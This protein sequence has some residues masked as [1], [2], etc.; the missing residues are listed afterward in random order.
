[1]C[2]LEEEAE[3]KMEPQN[4][5]P[6]IHGKP[7]QDHQEEEEDG[8][9][10]TAEMEVDTKNENPYHTFP[11]IGGQTNSDGFTKIPYFSGKDHGA[12]SW[13]KQR[14]RG[15]RHE[16]QQTNEWTK[17]G[18]RMQDLSLPSSSIYLDPARAPTDEKGWAEMAEQLFDD[19]YP[20]T[21]DSS[22][23]T[24]RDWVARRAELEKAYF[25]GHDL[26]VGF[27]S[28]PEVA[29]NEDRFMVR[30]VS[31]TLAVATLVRSTETTEEQYAKISE[32]VQ[33]HELQTQKAQ[34]EGSIGEAEQSSDL[35]KLLATLGTIL[36]QATNNKDTKQKDTIKGWIEMA[37]DKQ[38]ALKAKETN[39]DN[40]S[41][42][43]VDDEDDGS[44]SDNDEEK[45]DKKTDVDDADEKDEKVKE[46]YNPQ[47]KIACMLYE[48]EVVDENRYMLDEDG[49]QVDINP[50]FVPK[51]IPNDDDDDDDT[52][53]NKITRF[54]RIT[55]ERITSTLWTLNMQA[56]GNVKWRN[57]K[58]RIVIP[59]SFACHGE[60]EMLVVDHE[61]A[62]VL[63]M[64]KGMETG[65]EYWFVD[66]EKSHV[67]WETLPKSDRVLDENVPTPTRFKVL[68][69]SINLTHLA[70][71]GYREARDS[72][73]LYIIN[74]EEVRDT[75]LSKTELKKSKAKR[76]VLKPHF[77]RALVINTDIPATAITLSSVQSGMLWVGFEDGS[78][79]RLNCDTGKQMG[80]F[81]WSSTFAAISCIVERGSRILASS[82]MGMHMF[83]LNSMEKDERTIHMNL[84]HNAAFDVRGN[85]MILHKS[86]NAVQFINAHTLK[87]ESTMAAPKENSLYP[88]PPNITSQQQMISLRDDRITVVHL[89]GSRRIIDFD[90]YAELVVRGKSQH[91]KDPLSEKDR[92]ASFLPPD[93]KGK[94]KNK[95]KKQKKKANGKNK[96]K[97]K[98]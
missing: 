74:R 34:I 45:E 35:D 44:K 69:C 42:D 12:P 27:V 24:S 78:L 56:K 89:D 41:N 92:D 58:Q 93:E 50:R 8:E 55:N 10:T 79:L 39:E 64:P 11:T 72:P 54:D 46:K 91:G 98:K 25:G 68:V 90:G 48:L 84:E 15:K 18:L 1:V 22:A 77:K 23:E 85:L 29:C 94:K 31:S 66:Y 80:D 47:H 19:I 95:K 16:K 60:Y 36:N 96:N 9:V 97:K 43:D 28:R 83:R 17:S 13:T 37:K 65:E 33:Q 51:V 86:N 75:P 26:K 76:R 52:T 82:A 71:L 30:I 7:P 49:E 57:P 3:E 6:D 21:F 5:V 73:T 81:L 88:V 40:K 38:E 61:R 67:H 20:S 87:L 53:E 63:S 32:R 14:T 4:P 70:I 62:R 59:G 2:S